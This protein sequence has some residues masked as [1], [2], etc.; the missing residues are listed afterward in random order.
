[1]GFSAGPAPSKSVA[2][3]GNAFLHHFATYQGALELCPSA[4]FVPRPFRKD[5]LDFGDPASDFAQRFL[6]VT[7]E[8]G[9]RSTWENRG[10]PLEVA[11]VLRLAPPGRFWTSEHD[12]DRLDGIRGLLATLDAEESEETRRSRLVLQAYCR[13]RFEP[14]NARLI[15][16]LGWQTESF[17]PP[18]PQGSSSVEADLGALDELWQT[19]A[20]AVEREALYVALESALEGRLVRRSS[21]HPRRRALRPLRRLL[22]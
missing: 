15:Q 9:A 11:N 7:P 14:G 22:G 12:N 3:H 21:K 2:G 1:M 20:S 4:S 5:L 16:A 6:E 17:V 19:R 13:E 8:P 10:L 18:L